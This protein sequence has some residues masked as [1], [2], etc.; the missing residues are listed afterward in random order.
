MKKDTTHHD[1]SV[2][3]HKACVSLVPIFNHLE[4]GQ[5]DEIMGTTHSV[6]YQKHELIYHA[7]DESNALYIVNKGK[8]RIYRLSESGKEQLVRILNPGDFTGEMAL[9]S[10]ST[11]ETYA[12]AMVNTKICMINR[13][14]LQEFLMKYPSIS[15]KILAEFSHRL[16]ASEKQSSRFATEK[17]D[18]R[19][20]LFLVDYL[21]KEISGTDELTLPM[22]KKDLASYLGTTPETISRKFNELEDRGYIKQLTHK[23]IRI[24]DLD[25]LLFV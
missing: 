6:S 15:L 5:L 19:I 25:G 18:T 9:F 8:V 11:H 12:E 17:V 22:S 7:G 23:Q 2:E 13:L 4:D 3:S 20:A 24:V 21:D 1:H 16:D 14:D 10:E